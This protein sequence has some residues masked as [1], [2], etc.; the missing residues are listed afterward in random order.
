M[1]MGRMSP[2]PSTVAPP[3][4]DAATAAPAPA[5]QGPR[6]SR[7]SPFDRALALI[8]AGGFALRLV[9]ILGFK[10]GLDACGR[11]LCGDALWYSSSAQTVA[12]GGGFENRLN[13]VPPY[14]PAADHPPL[15]TLLMAPTKLFFL[16]DS[17]LAQRIG[18]AL[19]GTVAIVLVG[20]LTHRL[21][22]SRAALLAAGLA[23]LNPNFWMNDV[24][25]MSETV[26]T[27]AMLA[28]LLLVYRF[29]DRPSLARIAWVGVA[30]GFAGLARAELLLFLPVTVVPVVLLARSIPVPARLGRIAV[31]G[32]TAL[33]VL[34]PWT[35]YN[36]PRFEKPVLM[37]TNDGITLLGANCDPVYGVDGAGGVGFWNLGCTYPVAERIPP[38]ADQSV[39]SSYYRDAG[40]QYIKD[41]KR[42]VPGVVGTRI[43]R[44]FGFFG[45]DQMVWLNEGEG[46]DRWA[47]WAGFIMWWVMLVPAVAGVVA[48]RRRRVPLW[49][50][51]STFVIVLITLTVFYGIVRFRLPAD[52]AVV[53]LAG[54]GLDAYVLRPRRRRAPAGVPDPVAAT[55]SA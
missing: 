15:T 25:V 41:H 47:S 36:A 5:P 18:M 39:V 38:G 24:I 1:L 20:L 16:R 27:V 42:L 22:G 51:L 10:Q 52:I 4:V 28:V 8:A 17:V 6:A 32:G 49:P 21:A 44:G 43:V 34:V 53:V 46:R 7:F 55:G 3:G 23:A 9:I 13:A 30:C 19:L 40:I 54:V 31:A 26:G 11:E 12:A 48:L 45:P 50:L 14:S 29:V 2:P 37:S 35:L 33:L